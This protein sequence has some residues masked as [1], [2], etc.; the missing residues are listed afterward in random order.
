MLDYIKS[1]SGRLTRRVIFARAFQWGAYGAAAAIIIS[2]ALKLIPFDSFNP[3]FISV[4]PAAGLLIGAV[5]GIVGRPSLMDTA[6]FL[7]EKLADRNYLSTFVECLNKPSLN[8]VESRLINS[9]E[10]RPTNPELRYKVSYLIMFLIA[11]IVLVIIQQTPIPANS[12]QTRNPKSEI[13]NNAQISDIKTQVKTLQATSGDTGKELLAKI[14]KLVREMEQGSAAPSMML[15][16][17]NEFSQSVRELPRDSPDAARIQALLDK[18]QEYYKITAQKQDSGFSRA[19]ALAQSGPS[20]AGGGVTEPIITYPQPLTPV[21]IT[22][23][24]LKKLYEEAVARP[25]WP[26]QYDEVIKKYFK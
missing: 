4:L 6:I 13:Q 15:E 16:K 19:N 8:P 24:Y 10:Q 2:L 5:A 23:L 20:G 11:M 14:E 18:L 3:I 17:L 9:N 12:G 1:V 7:D 25:Y 26:A 22:P 21:S